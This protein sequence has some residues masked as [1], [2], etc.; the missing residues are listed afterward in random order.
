VLPLITSLSS[1]YI[2][3]RG[4]N[5]VVRG[6]GFNGASV[7]SQIQNQNIDVIKTSARE[8]EVFH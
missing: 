3:S 8:I 4:G 6:F 2:T 5:I 7:S 1:N